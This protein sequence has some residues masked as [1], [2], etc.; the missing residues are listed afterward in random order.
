MCSSEVEDA[1]PEP[2]NEPVESAERERY[3]KI[4]SDSLR[5]HR[6]AVSSWIRVIAMYTQKTAVL[7]LNDG[8]MSTMISNSER[9]ASS[10]FFLYSC[11]PSCIGKYLITYVFTLSS[12]DSFIYLVLP[13]S[14][15]QE[16]GGAWVSQRGEG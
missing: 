10:M 9:P 2:R 15:Q 16:F 11:L 12:S 14:A 5:T 1:A 4:D 13:R 6:K 7:T 3:Q 8:Y